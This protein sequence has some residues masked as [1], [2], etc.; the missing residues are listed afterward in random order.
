[1]N[2]IHPCPKCGIEVVSNVAICPH[3]NAVI[4][5]ASQAELAEHRVPELDEN[6]GRDVEQTI[7]G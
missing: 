1:M 5:P 6:S 3:C 4:G 7:E 2:A